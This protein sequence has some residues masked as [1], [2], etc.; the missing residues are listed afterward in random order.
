MTL[1][2]HIS[3]LLFEKFS[4]GYLIYRTFTAGLFIYIICCDRTFYIQHILRPDIF[5]STVY[6]CRTFLTFRTFRGRTFY[7]H[8]LPFA[9]GHFTSKAF[10]GRTFNFQHL[11]KSKILYPEP[12]KSRAY[13]PRPFC[14]FV[15]VL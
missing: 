15:G 13:A 9:A 10:S 3:L 6:C 4:T 5:T 7:V 14:I 2:I 12:F 11:S 8:P 1:C